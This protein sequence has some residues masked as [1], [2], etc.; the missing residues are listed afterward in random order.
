MAEKNL[1]AQSASAIIPALNVPESIAEN[2]ALFL[3]LVRKVLEEFDPELRATFDVLL[4]DA[5]RANADEAGDTEGERAAFA[6]LER[7][8]GELDERSTTLLMR[9]FVAY[10]HLANICEEN[11]RVSS[12][13]AR[14]AAVST[15]EPADPLTDN[16]VA[17]R[18]LVD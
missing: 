5:V 12:L 8:I 3:R 15:D 13:R 16:T 7:I 11:Y 4:S 17:Y 9:A 1:S 14:E 6:E 18:Q 2:M 10:F